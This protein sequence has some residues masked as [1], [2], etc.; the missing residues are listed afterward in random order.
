MRQRINVE[1]E[2]SEDEL[3]VPSS[4]AS[5]KVDGKG[6]PK[7]KPVGKKKGKR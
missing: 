6:V 5:P 2:G 7:R 3:S 1:V 4:K